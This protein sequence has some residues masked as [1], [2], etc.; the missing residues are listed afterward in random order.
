M[1]GSAV[2]ETQ[3]FIE[4][5]MAG[6]RKGVHMWLNSNVPGIVL[7]VLIM[8]IVEVTGLMTLLGKILG[9]VMSIF[10]L[11]GEAIVPYLT[12]LIS[13][14]G[15]CLSAVTLLNDGILTAEH[16]TILL[17]MLM[18]TGNAGAIGR[19]LGVTG[20][21]GKSFGACYIIMILCTIIAGLVMRII[22]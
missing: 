4:V 14:P 22:V 3:T 13:M 8:R 1:D 20:V 6:A 16:V 12:C 2:K 5:F 11:P 10:A 7:S 9:P 19:I 15:G 21:K 17:P 18:L